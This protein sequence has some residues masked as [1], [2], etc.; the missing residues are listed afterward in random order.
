[1][2]IMDI[3]LWSFPASC[4]SIILD[5]RIF[6][7]T[8]SAR[9]GSRQPLL[10]LLCRKLQRWKNTTMEE[11]IIWE[12]C[13]CFMS[14]YYS[15][16]CKLKNL[17]RTFIFSYVMSI[18]FFCFVFVSCKWLSLVVFFTANYLLA[19]CTSYVHRGASWYD[20]PE[21]S[22][23]GDGLFVQGGRNTVIL[24]GNPVVVH[25]QPPWLDRQTALDDKW[26]RFS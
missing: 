19:V 7:Q 11:S 18:M 24:S 10:S 21:G 3:L 5:Q 26:S 1:M 4:V 14:E 16:K 9:R 8:F 25:T 20:R 2:D 17:A 13:H 12:F 23:R 6:W 22:G 15:C